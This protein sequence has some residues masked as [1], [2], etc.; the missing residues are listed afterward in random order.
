MTSRRL[1]IVKSRDLRLPSP[2]RSSMWASTFS[3]LAI[4]VRHDQLL[5]LVEHVVEGFVLPGELGV[6]PAQPPRL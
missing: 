5:A 3:S 2:M 6:D 1:S 4:A